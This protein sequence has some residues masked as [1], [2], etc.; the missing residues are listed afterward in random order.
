MKVFITVI[1]ILL[2]LNSNLFPYR[3]IDQSLTLKDDLMTGQRKKQVEANEDTLI[4]EE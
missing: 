2:F 4:G 1:T 3:V